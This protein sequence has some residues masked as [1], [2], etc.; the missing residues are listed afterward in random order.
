MSTLTLDVGLAAKLKVAFARNGWTE[1]KIDK[2]CAGDTLGDFLHVLDGFASVQLDK[3]VINLDSTEF[4]PPNSVI[5]S[6]KK[7]GLWRWN[8]S[9]VQL[10]RTND[11][12]KKSFTL[13]LRKSGSR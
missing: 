7:G 11:R 1:G 10:L 8:V 6:H 13:R 5:D 4:L 2:L 9:E 3:D 12:G